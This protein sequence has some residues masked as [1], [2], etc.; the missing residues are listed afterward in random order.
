MLTSDLALINPAHKQE[1]PPHKRTCVFLPGRNVYL[2]LESEFY[3]ASSQAGHAT[4]D[5]GQLEGNCAWAQCRANRTRV[6]SGAPGAAPFGGFLRPATNL[7][8]VAISQALHF[9]F[10]IDRM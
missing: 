7:V 9:Q 1:I 2:Y 4:N 5:E 6:T 3:T 10:P 8:Q